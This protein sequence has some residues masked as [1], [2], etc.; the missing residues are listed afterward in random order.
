MSVALL[1]PGQGSQSVGMGNDLADAF[2]AAREIFEE[3]DEILGL[4]LSR[5]MW[6]GPE[7]ALTATEN[8]QPAL[9]VHSLA[10]WEVIRERVTGVAVAAGHSLGELSAHAAAGTY[11]F[12]DGLR[13]VR[14]RGELMARAGETESGSMAALLG[15][16]PDE[17]EA[18]CSRGREAGHVVVAANLN[19]DG[20]VVVSGDLG[21]IAWVEAHGKEAG[22][23]RVVRLNVS[24]AFHSPLMAPAALEFA[25][26]LE[27]VEMRNPEFPVESNVLAERVTRADS[28]PDLLVRQLTSPVRWKDCV[29]DMLAVGVEAFVEVGPGSVLTGLNRRNAKGMPTHST[30]TADLVQALSF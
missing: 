10:T 19:A 21:G 15:L 24:G 8:A 4:H 22:A 14:I 2:P 6:E 9:Y 25:R 29:T 11:S 17:A 5:I 3:A 1:F 30:G 23:K 16:S 28:V 13:T 12:A 7:D 26:H 20:Q 18:L 27:T